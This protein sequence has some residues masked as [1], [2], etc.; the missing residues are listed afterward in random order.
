MPQQ[1]A[2]GEPFCENDLIS[3]SWW[4]LTLAGISSLTWEVW[5]W[6]LYAWVFPLPHQAHKAEITLVRKRKANDVKS[7]SRS[8]TP[9]LI[10]SFYCTTL[11]KEKNLQQGKHIFL[12]E[13]RELNSIRGCFL[14]CFMVVILFNN[15]SING[16][17]VMSIPTVEYLS[18]FRK[19]LGTRKTFTYFT[20][21]KK[22]NPF[23]SV[24][25]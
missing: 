10:W 4:K 2:A 21:M 11:K 6:L 20:H 3:S 25:F 7:S 22:M 8:H 19:L 24:S 13:R 17:S 9:Y 14:L 1:R 15:V 5:P 12:N 18:W 23:A 16:R